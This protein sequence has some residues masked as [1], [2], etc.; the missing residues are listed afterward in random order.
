MACWTSNPKVVECLVNVDPENVDLPVADDACTPLYFMV[1]TGKEH[2]A[3]SVRAFPCAKR[4]D[5]N[6]EH[7]SAGTP[8]SMQQLGEN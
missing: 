3:D 4:V 6:W 8:F 1:F 5:V 2:A 7:H